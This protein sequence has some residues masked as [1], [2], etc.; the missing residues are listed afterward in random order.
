MQ[1]YIV[2]AHWYEMDYDDSLWIEAVYEKEELAK[3]HIQKVKDY[4]GSGKGERRGTFGNMDVTQGDDYVRLGNDF[5]FSMVY[6]ETVEM[7]NSVK[8]SDL[9]REE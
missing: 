6:Y 2:W 8:I 1:V 5:E 4:W 9:I 7:K 3:E